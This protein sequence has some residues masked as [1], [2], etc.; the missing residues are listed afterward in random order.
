M[1]TTIS[2]LNRQIKNVAY[3]YFIFVQNFLQM[4]TS[5]LFN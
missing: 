1:L 4:Q 5:T 2:K 3:T